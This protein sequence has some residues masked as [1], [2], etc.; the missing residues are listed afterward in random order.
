PAFAFGQRL[1]PQADCRRHQ[2][3]NVNLMFF[4]QWEAKRGAGI[5]RQN[6]RSSG[7]TDAQRSWRTHSVVMSRRDRAQ[8]ACLLCELTN[9]D[10]TTHAVVVVVMSARDQL[11]CTGGAAG[12]LEIG[13][14]ISR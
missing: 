1:Q 6:N 10:A 2:R 3:G 11:W 4:N 7:K 13:H 14:F 8:V 5:G 9:L 12:K